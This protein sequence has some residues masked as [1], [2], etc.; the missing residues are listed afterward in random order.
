MRRYYI[1]ELGHGGLYAFS[2]DWKGVGTADEVWATAER[3]LGCKPVRILWT[4]E[5]SMGQL[6]D[7]VRSSFDRRMTEL[8]LEAEK[9]GV[10]FVAI[11]DSQQVVLSPAT[12]FA[13]K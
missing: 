10:S 5:E 11:C 1:A 2:S 3:S 13:R 12:V 8:V 6:D 4:T 9:A 7:P